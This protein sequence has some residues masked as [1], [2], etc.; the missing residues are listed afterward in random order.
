MAFSAVS[1]TSSPV[2][3]QAVEG[4]SGVVAR[5]GAGIDKAEGLG[6][7]GILSEGGFVLPLIAIFAVLLAVLVSTG[8]DGAPVSP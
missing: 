2:L 7:N 1:L 4:S 5:T 8:N 6:G 3:A